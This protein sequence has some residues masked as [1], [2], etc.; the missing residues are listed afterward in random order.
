MFTVSDLIEQLSSEEAIETKKLEK[1]L[2]ISPQ[3]NKNL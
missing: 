3:Y 1:T 2:K